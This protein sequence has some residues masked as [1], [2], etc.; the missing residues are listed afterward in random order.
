MVQAESAGLVEQVKLR[1][2]TQHPAPAFAG[3]GLANSAGEKALRPVGFDRLGKAAERM[4]VCGRP[5]RDLLIFCHLPHGAALL[6]HHGAELF[7]D[8]IDGPVIPLTVLDPFEV[9]D[10]DPARISTSVAKSVIGRSK[11]RRSAP[12]ASTS[13]S[14][15][16]SIGTR[17]ISN[18]PLPTCAKC[19]ARFRIICSSTSRR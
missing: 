13:S 4:H 12:P 11:A 7:V 8:V 5:H 19:V 15:P 3:A 6:F 9:G 14:A 10:G 16:S 2:G 18:G 1:C 17:S